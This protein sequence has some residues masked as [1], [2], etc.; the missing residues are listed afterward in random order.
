MVHKLL[1]SAHLKPSTVLSHICP[2]DK[3]I[4]YEAEELKRKK[5]A[6]VSAKDIRE[7]KEMAVARLRNE[8]QEAEKIGL[9][10]RPF[11]RHR[12]AE[13]HCPETQSKGA[14]RRSCIQGAC[15]STLSPI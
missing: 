1:T 10:S 14:T 3:L 9:V 15:T 5:T 12:I 7:A 6:I 11:Y 13:Q 2:R 4:R 8:E